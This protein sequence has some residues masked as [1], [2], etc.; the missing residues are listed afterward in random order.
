MK[1]LEFS[2]FKAEATINIRKG[3]R[4]LIFELTFTL[5]WEGA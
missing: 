5:K 4:I 2:Q 3:K 1:L